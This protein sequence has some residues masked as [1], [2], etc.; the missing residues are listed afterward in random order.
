MWILLSLLIIVAS[1]G[2]LWLDEV[3]S[4]NLAQRAHS[5]TDVFLR[6]RHDNNHPINT[7]FMY[8]LGPQENLRW[9]RLLSAVSGIG[10]LFVVGHVAQRKWGRMEAIVALALAG[11]SYPLVLYFSEARGYAPAILCAVAAYAILDSPRRGSLRI[12][13]VAF[14]AV[15]VIGLLSHA[16]FFFVM[17]ALA[18]F[19][20]ASESRAQDP[21]Q[22]RI[23]RFLAWHALPFA[24]LMAWYWLF[25]VTW[26]SAEAPSIR[27]GAC[28]T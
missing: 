10:T 4:L 16:S 6:L 15:S 20:V 7:L 25:L 19:S 8:W 21:V 23:R 14:G 3:W 9:Y 13:R 11:T 12:R 26:S 24:A 22:E 17:L 28:S 5:V 2:D 1:R 27:N 18:A